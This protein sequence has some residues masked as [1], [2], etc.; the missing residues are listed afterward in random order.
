MACPH[1]SGQAALAYV[2]NRQGTARLGMESYLNSIGT[3]NAI[4]GVPAGT[5]NRFLN[6]NTGI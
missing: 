4:S 6:V 1:V 3:S 2:N 5:V